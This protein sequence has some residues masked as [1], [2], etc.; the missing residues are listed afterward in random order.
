MLCI[1]ARHDGMLNASAPPT[2]IAPQ[3]TAATFLS[4]QP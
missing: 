4:I 2:R 1:I 3:V